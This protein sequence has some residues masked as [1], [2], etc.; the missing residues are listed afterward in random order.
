MRIS[1]TKV[2]AHGITWLKWSLTTNKGNNPY[3]NHTQVELPME[4]SQTRDITHGT[5]TDKRH[6]LEITCPNRSGPLSQTTSQKSSP[7]FTLMS[8]LMKMLVRNCLNNTGDDTHTTFWFNL[9]DTQHIH[10]Q[11]FC[12]RWH[13]KSTPAYAQAFVLIDSVEV[14][15]SNLIFYLLHQDNIEGTLRFGGEGRCLWGWGF[16]NKVTPKNIT[17]LSGNVVTSHLVCYL[18]NRI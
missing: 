4:L 7:S 14:F 15:L 17:G 13:S 2:M 9:Q 5:S 11:V 6:N 10:S 8:T 18:N 1:W 3:D 12:L 16:R